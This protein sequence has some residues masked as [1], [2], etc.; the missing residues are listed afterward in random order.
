[1]LKYQLPES[2]RHMQVATSW[3]R[4]WNELNENVL[5][6]IICKGVGGAG[7]DSPPAAMIM[8]EN[9]PSVCK[10]SRAVNPFRMMS[11]V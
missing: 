4:D 1:M 8:K 6:Q 5:F 9:I 10:T 7:G 3:Q 2:I 11:R